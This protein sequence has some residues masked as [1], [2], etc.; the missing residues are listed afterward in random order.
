MTKRLRPRRLSALLVLYTLS[1]LLLAFGVF[2]GGRALANYIIDDVIYTRQSVTR[3]A[4]QLYTELCAFIRSQGI[5][6]VDDSSELDAWV[7]EHD[8]LTVFIYD[9][10][11]QGAGGS[12]AVGSLLTSSEEDTV[13]YSSISDAASTYGLL[14]SHYEGYWYDGPME[15]RGANDFPKVVRVMYFPMYSARN[16]ASVIC[17]VLA[18]AAFALCLTLLVRKKTSYISILS[19]QLDVMSAG[20]LNTPMTVRGNDELTDLA[21]NMDRMR[22]SFIERLE[23]EERMNKNA[24][25]LLTDMSHDLRTPLTALMGYLDILDG[26]KATNE[27]QKQKY[28]SS[29]KKRAYQIK[30]MTDEL[31][32]Y[33]LVY[34]YDDK[35]PETEALDGITLFMQLWD[36]CAL[37]LESKGFAC[38]SE[39]KGAENPRASQVEA[40]IKLTRRVFDNIVSN[41]IK[42][43]DSNEPVKVRYEIAGGYCS[44]SVSNAVKDK[45]EVAES[46][47]IGLSSC[48]KLAGLQNGT[49]EYESAPNRFTCTFALPVLTIK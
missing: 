49:F 14:Q 42:Y 2:I 21:K 27:E 44:V 25:S 38:E 33:F 23:N 46:S 36:E 35:K 8:Y 5:T 26:G 16:Y 13:M 20:E 10:Y 7:K 18:F 43:A 41:I 47:G 12:G 30:D 4:R 6:N 24:S 3:Q 15:V 1:A 29:A 40:D 19:K 37:G 11:K 32:E 17:A 48:K 39:I 22:L 28:I 34:S 31:F 45:P 9:Y